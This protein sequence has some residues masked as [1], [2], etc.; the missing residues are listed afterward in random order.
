MSKGS[1][2]RPRQ[3]SRAMYADNWD[4][5]FAARLALD[6]SG[7]MR[8]IGHVYRTEPFN[9]FAEAV[10]SKII[11][12]ADAENEEVLRLLVADA[13]PKESK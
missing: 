5:V 2:Q 13:A 9:A 6:A 12:S 10:D 7:A 1:K 4:I 11:A 3:V 8:S